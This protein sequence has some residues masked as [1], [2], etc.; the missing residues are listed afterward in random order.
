MCIT[1]FFLS[2]FMLFINDFILA[3][4]Y[5]NITLLL[6][7]VIEFSVFIHINPQQIQ[8]NHTRIKIKIKVL[9]NTKIF[10]ILISILF[11]KILE[12]SNVE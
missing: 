5:C 6:L 11:Q 10:K 12:L 4:Y 2:H 8:K 7:I 9:I 1:K 3:I